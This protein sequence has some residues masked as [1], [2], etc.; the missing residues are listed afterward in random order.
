MIVRHFAGALVFAT[1]SE[2]TCNE[3]RSV[4]TPV[5]EPDEWNQIQNKTNQNLSNE[6]LFLYPEIRLVAVLH[7]TS[8]FC[9]YENSEIQEEIGC[10]TI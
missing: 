6:V 9:H 8:E 4:E 1:N 2:T 3:V 10:I 7:L 5:K